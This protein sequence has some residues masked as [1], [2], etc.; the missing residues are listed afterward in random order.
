MECYRAPVPLEPASRRQKIRRTD[1]RPAAPMPSLPCVHFGSRVPRALSRQQPG[2]S[3]GI[4]IPNISRR[5]HML[6]AGPRAGAYRPSQL[7]ILPNGHLVTITFP[8]S[9]F[10][11]QFN[12]M[13]ARPYL[14]ARDAS[15]HSELLY[16]LL[17]HLKGQNS[18]R[19]LRRCYPGTPVTFYQEREI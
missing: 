12:S 5:P 15:N 1:F 11:R 9:P 19:K 3:P 4:S 8:I 13:F 6:P 16:E 14:K 2:R 7:I 18:V 17:V 10:P